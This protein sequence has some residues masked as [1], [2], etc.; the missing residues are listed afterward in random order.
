M[1]HA[2]CPCEER[3][4]DISAKVDGI[5]LCFEKTGDNGRRRRLAIAAR[6]AHDRAWAN[7]K[8]KVPSPRSGAPR[9]RR[10]PGVPQ[11]PAG[12]REF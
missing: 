4:T 6:N 3:H 1:T 5:S 12:D 10:R 8:K 2:V 9:G 11:G 7:L